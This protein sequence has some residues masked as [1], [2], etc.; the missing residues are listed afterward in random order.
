MT[1]I[2]T[3][4]GANQ[5]F[6]VVRSLLFEII[7][8]K[9]NL[10]KIYQNLEILLKFGNFAK[11]VVQS[12]RCLVVSMIVEPNIFAHLNDHANHIKM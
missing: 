7:F 11:I 12:K 9:A 4:C 5:C 10:S 8:F 1:A 6:R 2:V 3:L